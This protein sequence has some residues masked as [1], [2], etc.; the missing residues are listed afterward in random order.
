[1]RRLVRRKGSFVRDMRKEFGWRILK[2]EDLTLNDP[3]HVEVVSILTEDECWVGGSELILRAMKLD[4]C[5]GQHDAEFVLR[6]EDAIPRTW[7]ENYFVFPA[8]VWHDR[9]GKGR[10]RVS[11][12]FWNGRRWVLD[13]DWLEGGFGKDVRLI[14][15]TCPQGETQ[16]SL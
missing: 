9:H 8:T 6:Y 2:D 16:K 3:T 13:F 1:M 12:L 7:R 11:C 14:R 10:R 5:L 4:A 15:M